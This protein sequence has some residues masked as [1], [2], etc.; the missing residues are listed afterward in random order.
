MKARKLK[1]CMLLFSLCF[2]SSSF[3]SQNII[4]VQSWEQFAIGVCT[5]AEE[6]LAP[7]ITKT[8]DGGTIIA[9]MD[10]RSVDY[11]IYAQKLDSYGN[12]QW[13]YYSTDLCQ[14][15]P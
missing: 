1:I 10:N 6:Q 13:N 5:E 4:V 2:I 15:E 12:I 7:V 3:V 9:W 8:S 11:D 14:P